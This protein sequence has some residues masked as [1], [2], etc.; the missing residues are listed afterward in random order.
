MSVE[1]PSQLIYFSLLPPL[2]S[3]LRAPSI[4][5]SPIAKV[6]DRIRGRIA[7]KAATEMTRW[8]RT[9]I[10]RGSARLLNEA[11]KYCGNDVEKLE[12]AT[13]TDDGGGR[14]GEVYWLCQHPRYN[15]GNTSQTR[16]KCARKLV[17][18]VREGRSLPLFAKK[19]IDEESN[20]ARDRGKRGSLGRGRSVT[21][22][23]W[24]SPRNTTIVKERGRER[25]R[26]RERERGGGGNSGDYFFRVSFGIR[27]RWSD[28]VRRKLRFF[29]SSNGA[30]PRGYSRVN[31][32]SGLRLRTM[33]RLILGRLSSKFYDTLTTASRGDS[34][35]P[36]AYERYL[37]L[38]M[39]K[40][41]YVDDD[42][43]GIKCNI[44]CETIS[45]IG[46][47]STA[48]FVTT[49]QCPGKIFCWKRKE[50]TGLQC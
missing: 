37:P 6:S 44:V 42:Y 23:Q 45:I 38:T 20:F 5:F 21:K 16:A 26:E 19:T 8:K 40:N 30:I 17:N 27:D 31:V 33:A 50:K 3:S 48:R 24:E 39:T 43:F 11:R 35:L 36:R 2:A 46:V 25:E 4:L 32:I 41:V 22:V 29:R 34:S 28:I 14:E 15:G 1:I 18:R 49:A 13:A 47:F 12:R 7:D 9:C 10:P